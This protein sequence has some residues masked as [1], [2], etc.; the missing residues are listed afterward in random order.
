M[1]NA[2]TQSVG[3]L[4]E[5]PQYGIHGGRPND[6][7]PSM[8]GIN[9]RMQGGAV[10]VFNNLTFQEVVVETSGMTAER[11]TGGVQISMVPKDGG[12]LLSGTLQDLEY[13]SEPAEG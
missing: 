10:Y 3:N 4:N 1:A 13:R 7:A 12:N 6:N 8:D 5:R 9:Q 2:G 11:G